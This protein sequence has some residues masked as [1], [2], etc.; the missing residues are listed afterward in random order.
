M[1]YLKGQKQSSVSGADTTVPALARHENQPLLPTSD[2]HSTLKRHG[3]LSFSLSAARTSS[4]IFLA[5]SDSTSYTPH[6]TH[7][8]L[9]RRF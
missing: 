2:N 8:K 3:T 7:S 6:F 4:T 1:D 5:A 9:I